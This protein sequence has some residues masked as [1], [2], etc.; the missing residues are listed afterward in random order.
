MT[1]SHL[2]LCRPLLLLPPIPPSIRVFSN[3]KP[4]T[5][6][7]AGDVLQSINCRKNAVPHEGVCCPLHTQI[8]PGRLW[9]WGPRAGHWKD[10]WDRVP[11][12]WSPN[13]AEKRDEQTHGY[14]PVGEELEYKCGG[15]GQFYHVGGKGQQEAAPCP[16]LRQ[17]PKET[18][19]C[20]VRRGWEKRWQPERRL[21]G[22]AEQGLCTIPEQREVTAARSQRAGNIRGLQLQRQRHLTPQSSFK[23][24]LSI[25]KL[26]GST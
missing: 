8:C 26:A 16:G 22:G 2:I 11:A 25:L 12:L 9:S 13:P 4:I 18:L 15:R 21:R 24:M 1:S 10:G 17:E 14:V 23:L 5:L 19:I 6:K 3:E 20:W 7:K